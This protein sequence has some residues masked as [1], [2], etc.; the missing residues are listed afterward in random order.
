M[1]ELSPGTLLGDRFEIHGVLGRGG[2]ATVYLAQD[3]SGGERVALKLLHAHLAADPSAR[4]RLE[5]EVE[6]AHRLDHPGVLVARELVE[7]EGQVG[8]VLPLHPGR[9]LAE[10]IAVDGAQPPDQV[11]RLGLRL[12]EALGAAHRAGV[13]HRDLSARNV[14]V[15][16]RGAPVLTDFGMARLQDLTQ[17]S[18]NRSRTS[19]VSR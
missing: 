9:T 5:R 17:D 2:M 16:E 3:R 15:D 10:R 7:L 19:M 13:L 6:A 14:L 1:A 18:A 4:H 11:R 12:A 8:L